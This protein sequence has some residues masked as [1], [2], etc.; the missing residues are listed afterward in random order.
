MKKEQSVYRQAKAGTC[1]CCANMNRQIHEDK[2]EKISTKRPIR[3]FDDTSY[4]K[5]DDTS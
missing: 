3:K 1:E 2:I 4:R 5:F